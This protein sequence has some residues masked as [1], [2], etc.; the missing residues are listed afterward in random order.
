MRQSTSLSRYLVL[1]VRDSELFKDL[2][3]VDI[4][5]SQNFDF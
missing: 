1:G 2:I 4:F 3:V 5:V